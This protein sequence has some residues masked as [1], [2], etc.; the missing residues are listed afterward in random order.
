MPIRIRSDAQTQ[1]GPEKV[2]KMRITG[3]VGKGTAI[4][5]FMVISALAVSLCLGQT[6]N[7]PVVA[8]VVDKDG[9]RYTVTGLTA[10]YAGNLVRSFHPESG[11]NASVPSRSVAS[12]Y[13]N[14]DIE[15]GAVT[16]TE[17]REFPFSSLRRLVYE[18][19]QKG[20]EIV[21]IEATDGSKLVLSRGVLEETD[22]SGQKRTTKITR[23]VLMTEDKCFLSGF[24]GRSK[25][26]S[27]QEGDFWLLD[28][29]IRSIEFQ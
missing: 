21:R 27:G 28:S 8:T 17:N 4:L 19:E 11:V 10:K 5:P 18:R 25:I 29:N 20:S 22:T 9:N 7:K 6:A 15:E 1:V 13:V 23:Y 14:I 3:G 26:A 12:L 16:A 24:A 2:R